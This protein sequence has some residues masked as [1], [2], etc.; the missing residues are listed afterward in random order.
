METASAAKI[1]VKCLKDVT[2]AKRMKDAQGAYWC[3]DCGQKDSA[4]KATAKAT[5]I[6][7]ADCRGKT[8]PEKIKV[9]D[10]ENVCESCA[11]ARATRAGRRD[12]EVDGGDGGGNKMVKLGAAIGTIG[13]GLSLIALYYLGYMG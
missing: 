4:A 12:A 2:N 6:V 5:K 3:V 8:A 9:I 1:C 11:A 10:G 13:I 7:C